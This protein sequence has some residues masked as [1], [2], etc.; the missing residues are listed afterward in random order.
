MILENMVQ[1]QVLYLKDEYFN[2]DTCI[3]IE[4]VVNCKI[5]TFNLNENLSQK[6]FLV[7]TKNKVTLN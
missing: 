3:E 1:L 4:M 2:S 7:L 5:F 6:I